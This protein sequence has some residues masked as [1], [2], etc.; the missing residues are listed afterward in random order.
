MLS[1]LQSFFLK[2]CQP[3]RQEMPVPFRF[4]MVLV[5]TSLGALISL[6]IMAQILDLIGFGMTLDRVW[7]ILIIPHVVALVIALGSASPLAVDQ[8]DAVLG[9][10]L[11]Q[12]AF[13]AAIH[14][15]FFIEIITVNASF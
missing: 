7:I 3:I 2:F 8:F 14:I 5:L 13:F 9:T 10:A 6:G 4:L 1:F 12:L 15:M 11:I